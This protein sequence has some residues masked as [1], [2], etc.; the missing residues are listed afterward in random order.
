MPVVGLGTWKASRGLVYTAV[1]TAIAAGYRMI[2]CA[3]DYGN[4]KEVG[5]AL[6]ECLAEGLV[7]RE[8][9]FIQAKLWNTNHRKEHVKLD[10]M[11][12]LEDL[13]LD[14]IDSFVIH[15]PQA[16]P[17]SGKSLGVCREPH[18][19]KPAKYSDVAGT[20]FPIDDEGYYCSDNECHYV[21]TWHAME[22][23]VEEGLVKAAGIS[24]FNVAQI[25]EVLDNVKKHKPTVLQ[26]ECHPY[27]QQKDTIDFCK[28][29]GIV[30][31]SYS[32]LGSGDGPFRKPGDPSLFQE[33]ALTAIAEKHGKTVGH[34]ALAWHVNRGLS[35]VPKSTSPHRIAANID[36]F[37]IVLDAEDMAAFDKLNKGWKH[38]LWTATSHHPDYP[39]KESLPHDYKKEIAPLNTSGKDCQE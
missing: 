4:E 10:L 26:N 6:Q 36:V 8:E 25:R 24:N 11:A 5:K 20:M 23:L 7:K 29:N 35:L 37:D 31:Q 33:P 21:E 39:F 30:F 14:Y 13:G 34:I 32:P 18:N 38:C 9:L 15:W 28:A 3:N 22:D 12:T 1:K 17:A 2:D 27:L 16:C 19:N